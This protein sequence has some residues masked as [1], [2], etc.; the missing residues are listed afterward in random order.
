M[1][2]PYVK[3]NVNEENYTKVNSEIPFVPAI[4]LKTKSGP[5]GTVETVRS[6]KD[7]INKFG[8]T[9]YTVPSA[10]GIQT[11]L[12]SYAYILVS[13]VAANTA[14]VGKAT[15]K[16]TD[17]S[18]IS[19]IE[20]NTTYKTDLFNGKGLKL[21]YDSTNKKLFVTLDTN[22]GVITSV[23]EGIDLSTATPQELEQAL[24]KIVESFNS[25]RCGV[26]LKNLYT[27]KISSDS[28]PETFIDLTE[29]ISEGSSGN[30]GTISDAD[31]KSAIDKFCVPEYELDVLLAPEFNGVDIVN[32][33]ADKADENDF[34]YISSRPETTKEGLLNALEGYKNSA[35]LAVYAPDVYYTN[36]KD[37]DKNDV[38]IPAAVAVLHA[39]AKN[40]IANKWGAPA[41]VN[42]GTLTL[43]KSLVK[44]F[45]KDELDDLYDNE[46]PVNM[47]S[48]ISGQGI[49]VWGQKT[50][51]NVTTFMDRI[52][53]SRLCKY[54][55]RKT[56]EMSYKYL[57]EPITES[58]FVKWET[59]VRELLDTLVT[60]NAISE[61][62]VKMDSTLNTDETKAQNKLIGQVRIKPLEVAEFID[63]DLV[64]TDKVEV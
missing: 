13:R 15:I 9:D 12:R 26:E 33:G 7:F 27:G 21:S 45:T 5:I 49:V 50:T 25:T 60:G 32:Y 57:F 20:A 11:Y 34:I 1:S 2:L 35:S 37:A 53:V 52:N 43:A 4:I 8:I 64:I 29:N 62:Q 22:S 23:K 31:I 24:D 55:K 39:Y 51:D 61:Y 58:L 54:V 19:L 14:V 18:A 10:F 41:G 6:E 16:S 48:N 36:L 17:S 38:A 42:R 44:S 56:Y 47:I 59:V 30:D 63:I 40:D 3:V 46:I 28:K